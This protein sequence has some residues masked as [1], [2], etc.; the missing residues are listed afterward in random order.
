[1]RDE[2]EYDAVWALIGAGEWPDMQTCKLPVATT[3]PSGGG[4]SG[5]AV[6][7]R[8]KR[9]RQHAPAPEASPYLHAPPPSDGAWQSGIAPSVLSRR[10]TMEA[11]ARAAG[12]ESVAQACPQ[13]H[14]DS[15]PDTVPAPIPGAVTFARIDDTA[16]SASGRHELAAGRLGAGLQPTFRPVKQVKVSL[17]VGADD[18]AVGQRSPVHRRL[19]IPP[20]IGYVCANDGE[21]MCAPA[22]SSDVTLNGRS[23]LTQPLSNFIGTRRR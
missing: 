12:A 20:G 21:K 1:M 16:S 13:C 2:G 7:E 3:R 18:L 4:S 9:Q 10:A 11:I 15:A 17:D 22:F 19:W 6:S 8:V 23:M 14:A 5:L